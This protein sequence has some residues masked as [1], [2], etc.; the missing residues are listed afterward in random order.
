MLKN[1]KN[2][3]HK[4]EGF[5]LVELIV[6]IAIMV[7]LIALLVPNVIGYISQAQDTANLSSA[8]AIYNA[9]NTA[10]TNNKSKTGAYPTAQ[11]LGD[12]L[13]GDDSDPTSKLVTISKGT[14]AGIVYEDL[15]GYIEAVWVSSDAELSQDT[16]EG[17]NVACYMPTVSGNA[18]TA[19]SD[20]LSDAATTSLAKTCNVTISDGG[21]W[22]GSA[23]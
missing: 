18:A 13:N 10:C 3:L 22:S 17:T 15:S 11:E 7:I 12:L 14:S 23:A 8:K 20:T 21:E 4:S 5:T 2:K 1:L 16:E 6:V 19:E 9:A